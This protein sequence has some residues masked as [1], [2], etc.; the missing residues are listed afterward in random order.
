MTECSFGGAPPRCYGRSPPPAN[1]GGPGWVE[2][3]DFTHLPGFAPRSLPTSPLPQNL[4]AGGTSR[5]SPGVDDRHVPRSITPAPRPPRDLQAWEVP[6]KQP[7]RGVSKPEE[8]ALRAASPARLRAAPGPRKRLRGC[9]AERSG[10]ERGGRRA[11]LESA[12]PA[13]TAFPS[14]RVRS[15]HVCTIRL[16]RGVAFT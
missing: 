16:D 2:G 14:S 7:G 12:R 3:G 9:G 15:Q 13:G 1:G 11:R 10:A 4:A 6:S 8:S 5:R